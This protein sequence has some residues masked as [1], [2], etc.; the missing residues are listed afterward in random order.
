MS[1]Y[2]PDPDD[3]ATLRAMTLEQRLESGLRFTES[4]RQF[5]LESVRLHHPGW[6]EEKVREE[7]RRWVRNGMNPA[8]LNEWW[9]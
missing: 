7:V 9:P 1:N 2:Q 5:K 3:I 6:S 4:A 8:E